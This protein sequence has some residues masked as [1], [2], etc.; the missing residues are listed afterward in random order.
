MHHRRIKMCIVCSAGGH[1]LE[2]TLATKTLPYERYY[3]T[4][5]APH[6]QHLL[7]SDDYYFVTDPYRN[8]LKSLINFFQSLRIYLREKPNVIITTGACVAIATCLI[9]KIFGAKVIIIETAAAIKGPSGTGKFLYP[10]ADLF[11]VQ[12]K[13]QLRHYKSAVYVGDL[14]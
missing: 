10:F 7:N 2:A 13:S 4:F 1:L 3:V 9:A 12:W 14:F 6:L 5:Y 8:V 11:F